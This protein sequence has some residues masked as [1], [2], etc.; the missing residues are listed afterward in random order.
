MKLHF[1]LKKKDMELYFYFFSQA[2]AA[3]DLI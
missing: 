2:Q 1:L 3:A